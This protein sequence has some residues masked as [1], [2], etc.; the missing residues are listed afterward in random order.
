M[1]FKVY[2]SRRCVGKVSCVVDM[3]NCGN[4]KHN[5]IEDVEKRVL[6]VPESTDL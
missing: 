5:F 6:N 3:H 1:F 2:Y 4:R